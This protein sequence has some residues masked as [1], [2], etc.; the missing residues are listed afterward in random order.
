MSSSREELAIAAPGLAQGLGSAQHHLGAEKSHQ[1]PR[2]ALGS[3]GLAGCP[4]S[5]RGQ[6]RRGIHPRPA[7]VPYS[8]LS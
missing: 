5:Q 3:P 7:A 6:Q 8:L 4:K 2:E 1:S